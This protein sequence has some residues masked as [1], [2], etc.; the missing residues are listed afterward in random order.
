LL[1]LVL[2]FLRLICLLV[3]NVKLL[4]L[5]ELLLA[6]P[7]SLLLSRLGGLCSWGCLLLALKPHLALVVVDEA[8]TT[9]VRV[10]TSADG[11]S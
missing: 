5:V 6:P 10:P 8:G 3:P 2:A 7:P 4:V 9:K 1:L 11:K